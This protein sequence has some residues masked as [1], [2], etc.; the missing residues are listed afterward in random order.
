M[1][2]GILGEYVKSLFDSSPCT[3]RFFPRICLHSFR[4]LFFPL[5]F[6]AFAHLAHRRRQCSLFYHIRTLVPATEKTFCYAKKSSEYRSMKACRVEG[7]GGCGDILTTYQKLPPYTPH[8]SH[9]RQTQLPAPSLP[10][11]PFLFVHF[12]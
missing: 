6:L 10:P 11:L 9:H 7:G 5:N 4:V 3:H 2:L 1:F 8:S 12:G